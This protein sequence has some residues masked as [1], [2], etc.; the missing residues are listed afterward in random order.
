MS[1]W[2]LASS[3]VFMRRNSCWNPMDTREASYNSSNVNVHLLTYDFDVDDG[4]PGLRSLEVDAAAICAGVALAHGGDHQMRRSRRLGGG[5]DSEGRPL[6]EA[7]GL[8]GAPP[9]GVVVAAAAASVVSGRR[10]RRNRLLAWK[11]ERKQLCCWQKCA[12][13]FTFFSGVE[14][15]RAIPKKST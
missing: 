15:T 7:Q 1:H 4:V 5:A 2:H 6:P 11:N 14:N 13:L 3:L 10:G 12:L 9:G 8:F